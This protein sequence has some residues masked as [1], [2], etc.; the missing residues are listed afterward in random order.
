[1]ESSSLKAAYTTKLIGALGALG[2]LCM[3]SIALVL[4]ILSPDIGNWWYLLTLLS[5]GA[6]IYYMSRGTRKEELLTC[7][8]SGAQMLIMDIVI[9]PVQV[10][11]KM[12]TADNDQTTDITV[13]GDIEEILRMARVRSSLLVHAMCMQHGKGFLVP[14]CP[15]LTVNRAEFHHAYLITTMQELDLVEKGMVRVKGILEQA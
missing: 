4:S 14:G 2:A 13:E 1:M 11:V 7:M 15:M 3:G 12:V 8:M 10:K 9:D 6:Y 5:P